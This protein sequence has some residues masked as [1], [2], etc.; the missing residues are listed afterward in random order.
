MQYR[1]GRPVG[2]SLPGLRAGSVHLIGDF[3]AG[4]RD[5]LE[6]ALHAAINLAESNHVEVHAGDVSFLDAGSAGAL[7]LAQRAAAAAGRSL[8]LV[9][10]SSIVTKVLN[11]LGI[12]DILPD[13]APSGSRPA[14]PDGELDPVRREVLDLIRD[15]LTSEP[16][17]L[18]D[19]DFLRLADRATLLHAITWASVT[20]GGAYGCN[21][22]LLDEPTASLRIAAQRGFPPEFLRYF[23]EVPIGPETSC[24]T[25]VAADQ[26]EIVE[27]IAQSPIF[28]GTPSGQ[29]LTL[30]GTQS[31]NTYPL[32]DRNGM[33]GGAFSL[34]HATR[35]LPNIRE[36]RIARAAAE[37]WLHVPASAAQEV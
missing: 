29:I 31:V 22:Q 10:A 21:V 37:A 16:E 1:R 18:L 32:H 6:G 2:L 23:A 35:G 8:R 4:N 20:A 19:R 36:Q 12:S 5:E 33:I 11:A 17:A 3:D 7:F 9:D 24:G 34:H 14:S 26:P 25:A 28:A 15:R 13:H 30:A 27:N